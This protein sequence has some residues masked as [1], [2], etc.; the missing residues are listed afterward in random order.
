MTRVSEQILNGTSAQIGYT[1]TVPFTSIYAWKY[2]KYG[3]KTKQKQTL[4]KLSTI[5]K[6]QIT[7]NTAKQNYT[8]AVAFYHTRPGNEVGL[9]HKAPEPTRGGQ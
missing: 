7:Q 4:L 6:K 2:R 3:Q 5:H 9:F 8:G 1:Y